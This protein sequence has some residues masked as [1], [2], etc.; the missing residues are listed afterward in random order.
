MCVHDVHQCLRRMYFLVA[1]QWSRFSSRSWPSP[2]LPSHWW[3][4]DLHE[5]WRKHHCLGRGRHTCSQGQLGTAQDSP[6]KVTWY[7]KNWDFLNH[8]VLSVLE[9]LLHARDC[10]G[11]IV[12]TVIVHLI[13]QLYSA[14]NS[15]WYPTVLNMDV[16]VEKRRV[17]P[18]AGPASAGRWGAQEGDPLLFECLAGSL[19]VLVTF[20]VQFA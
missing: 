4:L 8:R 12:T 20:I 7:R 11:F 14:Y 16:S 17:V 2:T 19:K 18:G 9:L 6:E 1:D 3:Y 5:K 15:W 13:A 10:V